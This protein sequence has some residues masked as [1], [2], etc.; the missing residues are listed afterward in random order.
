MEGVPAIVRNDRCVMLAHPLWRREIDWF[1]EEQA[2]AHLAA[3]DEFRTVR[4]HDIRGFRLN[5]LSVWPDLA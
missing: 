5:P 2:D 3:T 4:W 1:T